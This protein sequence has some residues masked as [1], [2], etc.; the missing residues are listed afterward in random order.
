MQGPELDIFMQ[1]INN[2]MAKQSANTE[3][4]VSQED[5]SSAQDAIKDAT[6][7][8]DTSATTAADIYTG[9]INKSNK[10]VDNDFDNSLGCK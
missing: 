4:I 2:M 1:E 3:P 9:A 10:E 5:K 6:S 8:S 7:A